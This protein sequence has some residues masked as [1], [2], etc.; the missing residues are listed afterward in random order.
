MHQPTNIIRGSSGRLTTRQQSL[1]EV[2][3]K[4]SMRFLWKV[5]LLKPISL[6]KRQYLLKRAFQNLLLERRLIRK[7]KRLW[8]ERKG[9]KLMKISLWKKLFRQ[10]KRLKRKWQVIQ[11]HSE[12]AILHPPL[13]LLEGLYLIA[14]P[15]NI[16]RGREFTEEWLLISWV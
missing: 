4:G 11:D 15:G 12:E 6:S 1:H 2:K 16:Y 8:M 13:P 7:E 5:S 14:R 10:L 9:R 3:S